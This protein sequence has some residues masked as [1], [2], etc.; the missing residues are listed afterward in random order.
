MDKKNKKQILSVILAFGTFVIIVLGVAFIGYRFF[1]D[2]PEEV[3]GQVEV[4]QYRV[5]AKVSARVKKICVEE[6]QYIH[7]GDTLAILEAPEINAQE[8]AAEATSD[9]AQAL[10]DLKA[11]GSRKENIRAAAEVVK[12]AEAALNIAQKTYNRI[13]KLCSEGVATE[14]RRDEALAAVQSAEAQVQAAKS[15]YDL[16]CNGARYEERSAAAQQ[17]KAARHGIDVVRSFLKETVQI[18]TQNGEV[19][20]I[21][22]HDGEYVSNGTPI[23]NINM[24]DDVWG[25]FNIREDKL[26]NLHPGSTITAYS[27]A[28]NRNYKLQVYYIEADD[29]YATWKATKAKVGYDKRTFEV[30][31]RPIRNDGPYVWEKG[32]TDLRPGMLLILK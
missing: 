10:S 16:E 20:K 24:L 22:T 6:G 9:A 17:A 30:R 1:G 28:F 7:V 14:Q 2:E 18:A 19:D 5:S 25:T 27:P 15:K 8:E 23:M 26:K 32:K 13:E 4:R 12:Q 3:Q 21:Y 31:A 11:N 29:E